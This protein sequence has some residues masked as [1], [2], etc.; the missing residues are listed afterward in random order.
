[1]LDD[2]FKFAMDHHGKKAWSKV[3]LA[4][5]VRN[6]WLGKQRHLDATPKTLGSNDHLP[7]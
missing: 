4:G 6:T 7:T 3:V 5:S 1:M 2:E